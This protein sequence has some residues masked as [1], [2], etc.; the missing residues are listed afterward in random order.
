[1][2]RILI[3]IIVGT[4]FLSGMAYANKLYLMMPKFRSDPATFENY[5]VSDGVGGWENY[6]VSDGVGGWDN[7]QVRE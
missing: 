7:Y 5:Q 2:K 3:A 1:M 4:L 6:Q